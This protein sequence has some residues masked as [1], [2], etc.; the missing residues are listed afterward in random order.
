MSSA[1]VAVAPA[2]EGSIEGAL[3]APPWT[4]S[5]VTLE[6]WTARCDAPGCRDQRV[7]ACTS[8]SAAIWSPEVGALAHGKLDD[9]AIATASRAVGDGT[10]QVVAARDEAGVA[11]HELAG[12]GFRARTFL[13]FTADPPRAHACFALT[14]GRDADWLQTT[15]I[16]GSASAPPPT[17]LSLRAVGACAH[18][19]RETFA[20]ALA[21]LVLVAA[22]AI[23]RRPGRRATRP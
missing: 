3:A 9:L 16:M 7:T 5:A 21:A 12:D 18:H 4:A 10:M 11:V 22:L 14:V 13:A 15:H 6:T 23:A 1:D 20:S 2:P 17:A 19:P 8:T